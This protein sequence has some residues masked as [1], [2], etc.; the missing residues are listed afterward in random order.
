MKVLRLIMIF[1]V[2]SFLV[3]GC[4]SKNTKMQQNEKSASSDARIKLT[5]KYT[6]CVVKAGSDHKAVE[7]CDA[8]L[9]SIKKL[10]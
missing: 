4:T 6:D 5:K 2:A 8:I 9:D 10:K 3:M 1:G 7:A